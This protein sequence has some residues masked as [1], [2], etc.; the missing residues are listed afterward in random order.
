MNV[1]SC[2]SNAGILPA[3]LSVFLKFR[4]FPAIFT[5][6]PGRIYK[7]VILSVF[8]LQLFIIR[9]IAGKKGQQYGDVMKF[10]RKIIRFCML[11]T[12]YT[13]GTEEIYAADT[14]AISI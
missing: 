3:G 13:T 4:L 1:F 10:I 8:G 14:D 11:R 9:L 5:Q 7:G 2:L 12:R 6:T